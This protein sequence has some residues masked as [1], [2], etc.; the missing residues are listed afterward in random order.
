MAGEKKTLLEIYALAV[1]FIN[2]LIGSIA[3][4]IIVYSIISI[5][6]P[7]STLSKWE[8]ARYQSNHTFI[9]RQPEIFQGMP[10]TEITLRRKEAYQIALDSEQRAGKQDIVQFS[11]VL[12]IQMVLFAVH[13]R[14]AKR[15]VF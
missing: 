13:W 10:D 15:R 3:I 2:V 11:I 9:E 14:L 6:S 7:E 12:L 4:G 5:I 8:Y 1:C